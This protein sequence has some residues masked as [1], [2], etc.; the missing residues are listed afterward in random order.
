MWTYNSTDW[1]T[2]PESFLC[3]KFLFPKQNAASDEAES[4]LVGSTDGKYELFAQVDKVIVD[5]IRDLVLN[6]KTRILLVVFILRSLIN[7]LYWNSERHQLIQSPNA[8]R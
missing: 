8:M 7:K 3:S 4:T 2:K 6:G 1:I 5:E